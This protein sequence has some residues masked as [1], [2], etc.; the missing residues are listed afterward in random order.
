M[1]LN[2]IKMNV[3]KTAENG[4]VN[5][6]T[7]FTFSQTDNFISATYSG[8]AILQGYLVGLLTQNKLLFSYCQLQ[9][10]GKMDHGQSECEILI[11]NEKI[12]LVEHFT[13]ASRKGETGIN[14]FQQL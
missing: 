10:N 2:N 7:I 8:G 1:N 3:I 5:K 14:I 11:V 12:R 9:T 13:W 4:T 6:L